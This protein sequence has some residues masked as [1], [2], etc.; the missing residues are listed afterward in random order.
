VVA[1][2]AE[3]LA[4]Q[5]FQLPIMQQALEESEASGHTCAG[6]YCAAP[7]CQDTIVG[8]I[9]GSEGGDDREEEEEEQ[10]WG[11]AEQPQRVAAHGA[12]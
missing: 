10:G 8:G 7:G 11:E 1:A 9:S 3:Y 12:H 2:E 5:L 4:A 6:D